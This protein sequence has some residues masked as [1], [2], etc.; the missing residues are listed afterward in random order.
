MDLCIY[1]GYVLVCPLITPADLPYP[2]VWIRTSSLLSSVH[3]L[4]FQFSAGVNVNMVG[5]DFVSFKNLV[6]K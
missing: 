3:H 6:Q 2:S 1:A 5:L 4:F